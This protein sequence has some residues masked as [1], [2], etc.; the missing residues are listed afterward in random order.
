MSSLKMSC[1]SILANVAPSDGQGLA[2][3]TM[4]MAARVESSPMMPTPGVGHGHR[5]LSQQE[6]IFIVD[7]ALAV[8]CESSIGSP[9]E[10][11]STQQQLPHAE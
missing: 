5:K 6:I 10:D 9:N 1:R 11:S 4:A 2:A 7:E 8:V 3:S